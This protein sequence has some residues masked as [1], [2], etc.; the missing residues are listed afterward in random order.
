MDFH[1]IGVNARF[2]SDGVNLL[3]LGL[4]GNFKRGKT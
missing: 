2:V 3:R 1:F 4:F